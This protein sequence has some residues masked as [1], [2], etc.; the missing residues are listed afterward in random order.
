MNVMDVI[1]RVKALQEFEVKFTMPEEFH[2]NGEVP[3]DMTIVGNEATVKVLAISLEEAMY[4]I[5]SYFF[6]A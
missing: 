5:D 6:G 3:F 1:N 4:R 2:F